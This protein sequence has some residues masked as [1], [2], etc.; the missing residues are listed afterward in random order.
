M[1]RRL[2][3]VTILTLTAWTATAAPDQPAHPTPLP[4][5]AERVRAALARDGTMMPGEVFRIAVARSDLKVT[6][7]RVPLSPRFA[8][9]SWTS[10]MPVGKHGEVMVMGDLVLTPA[11]VDPVLR[12]LLKGKMR[13]TALHN[14][15]KGE[16]PRLMFLHYD[17]KGSAPELAA[18]IRE[19]LALTASPHY[20]T[21]Q[22]LVSE[23]EAPAPDLVAAFEQVQQAL[24]RDGKIAGKVLQLSFPRLEPV[25]CENVEL[26]PSMGTATQLNFQPVGSQL[27]ATGDFVLTDDELQPVLQAL[28][29]GGISIEAIHNHMTHEKPTLKFVHFYAQG[30]VQTLTTTLRAALDQVAVKRS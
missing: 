5:W 2:L 23:I 17:G 12:A 10:I 6:R 8:Y 25:R 29:S 13:V 20:E 28:A 3:L 14:H 19:A 26:P 1:R 18:T 30:S 16:T 27:A 4:P 9:T 24:G 11:E 7:D 21:S 22:E 15:L